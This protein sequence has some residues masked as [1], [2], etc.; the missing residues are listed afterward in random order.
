MPES[1]LWYLYNIVQKECTIGETH[2]HH[3]VEEYLFFTG[4][5]ISRF[6][7]FD[8]EIEISLGPDPEHL[9]TYTITEPTVVRIPA[10]VWHGPVVI[11]RLGA[12]I[13]FEPFYP[14]GSYGK[15]VWKDGKYIYDGKDLPQK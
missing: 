9:E 11:K 7:E 1:R 13:N 10:G 8:A 2:M 6:F 12:P 5:D 14:N 3:A 15:I 4:A